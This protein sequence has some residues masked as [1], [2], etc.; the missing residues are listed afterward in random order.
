MKMGNVPRAGLEPT[1]LAFQAS[2][3][4]L[5][6]LGSLMSPP[7]YAVSCIRGQLRL[8]HSSPWNC[9]SFNAY[10]YINTGNCVHRDLH[11]QGTFSTHTAHRLYRIMVIATSVI[12]VTKMKILCLE[13]ESNPHLYH[14]GSLMSPLY[15]C[16][17]V[18]TF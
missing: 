15:P 14:V 7:G 13:Q 8:L 3:L 9:K 5:H 12:S 4:L 17:P 6:Q 11:T 10:D 16:L 1:S 2:V 18:Y